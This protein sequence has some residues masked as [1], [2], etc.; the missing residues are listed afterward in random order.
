MGGVTGTAV[1]HRFHNPEFRISDAIFDRGDLGI[2]VTRSSE[3]SPTQGTQGIKSG[4]PISN[5]F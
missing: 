4:N 5:L 2:G 1:S 3:P